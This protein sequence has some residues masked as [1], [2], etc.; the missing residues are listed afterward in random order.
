MKIIT[1]LIFIISNTVYAKDYIYEVGGQNETKK[2]N[3]IIYPNGKKFIVIN[4]E[5][6]A[7]KDNKGDYGKERCIGY[8]LIDIDQSTNAHIRCISINQNGEKFWTT[9]NRK[10]A[11]ADGGGGINTYVAGTGKYEQMVGLKCP[12]GVKFHEDIVW[13]TH[14]CKID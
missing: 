1:I 14:K 13:Y 4:G 11:V 9:R 2:D 5:Y 7:W 3:I 8:V 6:A 10:S 12:Y